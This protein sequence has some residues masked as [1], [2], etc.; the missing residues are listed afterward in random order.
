[1]NILI[2]QQKNVAELLKV[3]V[4]LRL[5]GM[6]DE[7]W[8]DAVEQMLDSTHSVGHPIA[9]VPANHA[10]TEVFLQR[11]KHLYIA[12]VLHDDEFRQD[13]RS[14][15]HLRVGVD[16]HVKTAFAVHEACDP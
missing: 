16:S 6:L 12:L 10:T 7:K 3:H 5:Q 4:L 15:R 11:V 13:L 8:N 9:V 1:M 2:H 14:C